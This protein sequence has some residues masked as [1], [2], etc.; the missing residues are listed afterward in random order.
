L[1]LAKNLVGA[2]GKDYESKDLTDFENFKESK[3]SHTK[4][5]LEC[6]ELI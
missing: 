1:I 5:L 2:I 3:K 4:Y 6:K